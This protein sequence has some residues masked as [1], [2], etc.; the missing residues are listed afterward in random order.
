MLTLKLFAALLYR[1][2]GERNYFLYKA[3]IHLPTEDIKPFGQMVEV[4]KP[5]SPDY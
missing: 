4:F 5:E 1:S 2:G 3:Q